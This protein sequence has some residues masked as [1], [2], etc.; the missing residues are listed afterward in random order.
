MTFAQIG[1]RHSVSYP[2]SATPELML[3]ITVREVRIG[4]RGGQGGL[5]RLTPNRSPRSNVPGTW[6]KTLHDIVNFHR[7]PER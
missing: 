1:E 7:R 2:C 5:T 4:Q 3:I 6:M